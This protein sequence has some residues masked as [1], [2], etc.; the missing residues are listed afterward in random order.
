MKP[1][2]HVP[3]VPASALPLDEPDPLLLPELLP[4]LL[5]PELLPLPELPLPELLVD[6]PPEL[7]PETEPLLE[8]VEESLEGPPSS[9]PVTEL[10]PDPPQAAKT[11]APKTPQRMARM[12]VAVAR[13][14]GALPSACKRRRCCATSRRLPG[15]RSTHPSAREAEDFAD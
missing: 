6:A 12:R 10:P 4:E 14:A 1:L 8:P 9:P 2:G 5:L 15:A 3:Q 7:L 13:K 11:A